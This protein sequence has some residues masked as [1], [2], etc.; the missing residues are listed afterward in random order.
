MKVNELMTREVDTCLSDSPLARAAQLMWEK[1]HGSVAVID[2]QARPV[3]MITDRDVCMGAYTTG[4]SLW[5][6]PVSRS[7]SHPVVVVGQDD[8]VEEAERLMREK[9]VRRLPVVDGDGKLVGILSLS[10][11]ARAEPTD[12]RQ[13]TR[14]D[15]EL[16]ETYAALTRSRREAPPGTPGRS[17]LL[18]RLVSST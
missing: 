18:P 6:V 4:S 13:R 17:R 14:F 11:L 16:V 10:D 2:G 15:H 3:G 9:M 7:M 8:D 1:D 5:D 12:A